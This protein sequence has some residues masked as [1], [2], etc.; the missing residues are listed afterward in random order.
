MIHTEQILEGTWEEIT[1]HAVRLA[2]KRVRVEV[3]ENGS[4]AEEVSQLPFYAT[5]TREERV[6]ALRE[7]AASHTNTAP[8][9]SEE[10]ICRESIY[11][12]GE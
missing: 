6:R 5:A 1:R 7:W 4:T 8:L 9:L 12:G 3:L 11:F 10:A 2:G